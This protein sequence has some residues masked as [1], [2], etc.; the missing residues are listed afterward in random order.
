MTKRLSFIEHIFKQALVF[1][2]Y[3]ITYVYTIFSDSDQ[4]LTRL[5]TDQ[6]DAFRPG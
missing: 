3:L 1:D 5:K 4:T 6:T 2:T